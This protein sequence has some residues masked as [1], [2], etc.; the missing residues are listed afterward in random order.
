[1]EQTSVYTP[2]PQPANRES[3]LAVGQRFVIPAHELQWRFSASGGPGGQHVNTSNTKAELTFDIAHSSVL[4]PRHRARLAEQYGDALR[5]VASDERS[6]SR[7]RELAMQRLAAR[8]DEALREQRTRRPTKPSQ[9]AR[10]RRL[11]EKQHRSQLKLSRR[12][13]PAQD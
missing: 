8:I 9:A 3:G 4:S 1:M 5:V 10:R 2:R 7:N 13:V 6:Q 12:A 11:Q